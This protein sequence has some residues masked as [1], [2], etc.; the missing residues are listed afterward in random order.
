MCKRESLA[1]LLIVALMLTFGCGGGGSGSTPT[2]PSTPS[3]ATKVAASG[4]FG[5]SVISGRAVFSGKVPKPIP[6][7]MD[8]DPKCAAV[9]KGGVDRAEYVVGRKKGLKW[10]FVYVKDMKGKYGKPS[11][12]VTL[13]QQGCQYEPHVFGIMAGQTLEVK[14]SDSW[15][16][17]IHSLPKKSRSF[18][19][20]QPRQGMVNKERFRRPEVM[21]R[22][23]CD[24][25]PWMES[26]AGVVSHP[27]YSVTG[28]DGSFSLDRLPAGTYTIEAWHEGGGKRG[29][30]Q[31]QT[32]TVG[33]GE[34]KEIT[35]SFKAS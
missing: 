32:V 22:I 6:I 29:G 1:L 7:K 31:T 19:K 28:D 24:V 12:V 33:D 18:N 14:N 2:T 20:A 26:W 13:D 9:H 4:N 17:N 35:F 23:K 8:A 16:H 34:T 11:T 5:T 15:L 10:V 3:K 25:H 30:T 21:V 27:F